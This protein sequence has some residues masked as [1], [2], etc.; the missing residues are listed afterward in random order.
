[1][2]MGDLDECVLIIESD[3]AAA[4]L[5]RASLVVARDGPFSVER[6]ANLREGMEWLSKKGAK[7]ILLNL[8]L[9]DS[10]G[11]ET[12]NKLYAISNGIPILIM[13]AP[14]Q[15]DHAKLAILGGAQDYLLTGFIDAHSLSRAIRNV[16]ARQLVEE[17]LYLEKERAQVTLIAPAR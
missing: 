11:I 3:S 15:E 4:T 1:M 13:S 10:Q 5:I 12:F 6:V 17:E 9:S 16:M 14:E 7:A 2:S 8:F